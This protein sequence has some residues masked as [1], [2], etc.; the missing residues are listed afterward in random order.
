MFVHSSYC[1]GMLLQRCL[2]SSI[3]FILILSRLFGFLFAVNFFKKFS[4][5]NLGFATD[6][7]DV[8]WCLNLWPCKVTN[9]CKHSENMCVYPRKYAQLPPVMAKSSV[10]VW[11]ERSYQQSPFTLHTHKTVT[12]CG[13]SI[14]QEL[15]GEKRFYRYDHEKEKCI[16]DSLKFEI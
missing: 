2:A 1:G 14:M 5:A 11:Y 9:K 3:L 7:C 12:D 16:H 10:W 13:Q 8:K 6:M 15:W 4:N